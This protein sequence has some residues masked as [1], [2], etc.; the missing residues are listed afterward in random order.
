VT[1]TTRILVKEDVSLELTGPDY[2]S[3]SI[4]SDFSYNDLQIVNTGNSV[5]TL[6]W[7]N[8]LAPDGWVVGFS[9]P[10]KIL[11][12]REN[13][14]VSIGLVPPINEQISENSF[15][16]TVSVSGESNGRVVT[17]SLQLDVR[18]DESYFGNLSSDL[19]STQDFIGIEVGN[20]KSQI[21]TFRNDGNTVLD[22]DVSAIV[23]DSDDIAASG[24]DV[25]VS[26]SKI[27]GL[28]PGETIELK[29]GVEPNDKSKKGSYQ[30]VINVT[31]NS[32]LV[33]QTV[34]TSSI[35]SSKG[36]SGLFNLVPW[37]ISVL[38]LTTLL[39]SGVIFARRMKRSGSVGNDD[40]QLVSADAYVNPEYISDRRDEALNIGDS[41]NE[42]TSGEVSADEIAAA[43]AQ[44]MELP[45][46][47]KS[48]VP[49]GMPPKMNI[50]AGMPPQMKT[51]P[52]IPLP[53]IPPPSI[54]APVLTRPLPPTGL[55][56][57]WSV[58]QWN[59]YGHMWLEKN[60]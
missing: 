43:L 54:Q 19:G 6:D 36:N 57:G 47:A 10:A 17:Q 8:S 55:P 45:S 16:L 39:V 2:L 59:A 4:S 28:A 30:V 42:I 31:S 21:I 50:P 60:N 18:V 1:N 52:V 7:S 56:P 24:W 25:E 33:A 26:P 12:P 22:G 14:T 32:N 44:S 29:V 37:Y 46:F 15:I 23:L 40:S 38:I 34:L 48:S 41:V 3:T 53:Q 9:N 11:N 13:A 20:S 49:K 5:L 58:E 27:S 35:Q 51:L